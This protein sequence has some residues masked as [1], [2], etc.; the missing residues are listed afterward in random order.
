MSTTTN[1]YQWTQD[2]KSL[3]AGMLR[4]S[5]QVLKSLLHYKLCAKAERYSEGYMGITLLFELHICK[6]KKLQFKKNINGQHNVR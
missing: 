1:D 4:K 6:C 3:E 5:K 2:L